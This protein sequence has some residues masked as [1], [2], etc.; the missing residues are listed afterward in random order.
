MHSNCNSLGSAAGRRIHGA[1]ETL[2]PRSLVQRLRAAIGYSRP[3]ANFASFARPAPERPVG[4]FSAESPP[5]RLAPPLLPERHENCTRWGHR[6]RLQ[7]IRPEVRRRNGAKALSPDSPARGGPGQSR[8]C[9]GPQTGG[10][11]RRRDPGAGAVEGVPLPGL[12]DGGDANAWNRN[13]AAVSSRHGAGRPAGEPERAGNMPPASH[14]RERAP[15][16]STSSVGS[17]RGIQP[18]DLAAGNLS[19]GEPQASPL[20]P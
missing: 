12:G 16:G 8:S 2:R 14:P 18:E 4:V 15:G 6:R 13:A 20:L 9:A 17:H 10:S 5:N 1:L 3:Q 11:A 19:W 7:P